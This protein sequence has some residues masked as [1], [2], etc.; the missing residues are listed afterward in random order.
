MTR[1][2]FAFYVLRRL[3]ALVL[4]LIAISFAIFS[5][6]YIAPGSPLDALIGATQNPVTPELVRAMN[7]KYHLNEPFLTEYWMWLKDAV[8]LQFGDSMQT[9]LP[10]TDEIKSRLPVSLFL[11][12]YALI[13]T[14]VLG[15][16]FGLAAALK[17][18]KL[19]DRGIVTAS[20]VGL[21]TP[22]FVAGVFLLYLFAI[23]LPWFPTFGRGEGFRGQLWHL[24]LPALA[25]AIHAAA[26]VLKHTRAAMINVLDQDYVTFARARGLSST[27][28]LFVYGLRNGLIPIVTISGIL[29]S[30]LIVGAV[31]VEVTFSLPGIGG[32]L[33]QSANAKDL[34]LLQG[35][36][37]VMAVV[38]IV[39]NLLTDLLYVA[40]DPRIRLGRRAA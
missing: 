4:T 10:V 23:V 15:I 19:A 21:G 25:L 31:L 8:H 20:V 18:R 28:I 27:R 2:E 36:A 3:V 5:L 1:R 37:M 38:I 29:F 22:V 34:P 16:G 17:R 6:L 30:Y 26:Y 40:V 39:V 14:L 12:V 35:V 13:L 24:T 32:L 9:T 7:E 11:G 33:V